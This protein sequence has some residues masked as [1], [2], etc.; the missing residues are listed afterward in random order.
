MTRLRVLLSRVRGTLG[1]VHDDGGLSDEIRA[2]LELLTSDYVRQGMSLEDARIAARRRF[3]GVEQVKEEYRDQRGVSWL[4]DLGRD[5]RHA[6][7]TLGSAPGFSIVVVLTLALGIGANTAIFTVVN[8]LLLRTLP[9]VEPERLAVL[10]PGDGVG[11]E[12]RTWP[13]GVWEQIQLRSGLFDGVAASSMSQSLSLSNAGGDSETVEGVFVSGD[14]F[15]SLGVSP[16]IGRTLT[17]DDDVRGG[18]REGPVAVIS[19]ALWQRRFGGAPGVVGAPIVIDRIPFTVV[20]VTPSE[21]LGTEVGRTFDVAIPIGTEPLM[22]GQDSTIDNRGYWLRIM[23][24]LKRDQS[25]G[26]ATAFLRSVQP[27]IASDA[28]PESRKVFREDFL[29]QPLV[30]VPAA[31]GVSRL[32]Y[33]YERPLLALLVIAGLVLLIACANIANLLL[34]RALHRQ[35]ELQVRLALGAPRA[36]IARQLFT[37]SASLAACG[38]IL[39]VVVALWG[40]RALVSHLSTRT[41]PMTQVALDLSLDWRV[42]AFTC[43][44]SLATAVLFGTAPAFRCARLPPVEALKQHPFGDVN[45]A[46]PARGARM[47]LPRSLVAGQVAVSVILVVAAGLFVRTLTALD[48]HHL[49]FDRDSVLIVNVGAQRTGIDPAGRVA[50][51]EQAREAVRVVPGVARAAISMVTPLSGVAFGPDIHVSGP[52]APFRNGGAARSYANIVSPGWF[53]TMGTPVMAGRDF[54]SDDRRGTRPVVIVNET[55]ARTFV[56]GVNPLGHMVTLAATTP[57]SQVPMEVVGLVADATY[58]TLRDP[59]P[60]THVHAVRPVRSRPRQHR[61]RQRGRAIRQRS[62]GLVDQESHIGSRRCTSG[63]HAPVSPARRSRQRRAHAGAPRRGI[64]HRV[65]H[66]GS[67]AGSARHLR[68]YGVRNHA[69]TTRNRDSDGAWR[70]ARRSARAG[71][72]AERR[73]DHARSGARDRRRGGGHALSRQHALRADTARSRDLPR[74]VAA[75][76]GGR[77]RGVVHPGSPCD[78]G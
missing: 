24:R 49:G 76:R 73:R 40:S 63:P 30:A 70:T 42:V 72:E 11:R 74:R 50:L 2:H 25:P 7:R 22:R 66:A 12:L 69:A 77:H 16:L 4:E 27:Q 43:A 19:A 71:V 57:Y 23:L 75:V 38:G 26:A 65:W 51:Y 45:G 62:S 67:G 55:W 68:H 46:R 78:E 64:V 59:A 36:R 18:G 10:A 28:F 8:S 29:R 47:T 58:V 13:H 1:R 20:G 14:F 56:N 52:G 37:E 5:V 41:A 33:E 34:V 35:H 31:A 61:I 17:T 44:V 53:D 60:A 32:R 21:F 39:G 9:V 6:F 15:N 54:T 3:G 48:S